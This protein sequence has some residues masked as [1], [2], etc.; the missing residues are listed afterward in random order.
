[1]LASRLTRGALVALAIVLA[2]SFAALRFA[3]AWFL[4][5]HP[6]GLFFCEEPGLHPTRPST[7]HLEPGLVEHT[8]WI[9]FP[10]RTD[11]VPNVW[12]LCVDGGGV[13][14]EPSAIRG[15]VVRFSLQTRFVNLLWLSHRLETYSQPEHWKLDYET[16]RT[17]PDGSLDC[18]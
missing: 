7:I 13:S 12:A 10:I 18:R 16:C 6:I 9:E 11:P 4:E 14:S 17:L 8:N 1:M 15:N 2:G 3:P 5:E